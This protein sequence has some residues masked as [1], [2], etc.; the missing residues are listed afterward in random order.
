MLPL[1]GAIKVIEYMYSVKLV[2][3]TGFMGMYL[4][5]LTALPEGGGKVRIV[6][7]ADF[8][9]QWALKGLHNSLFKVLK[10]IPQDG[11]FDQWK[12]VQDHVLPRLCPDGPLPAKVSSRSLPAGVMSFQVNSFDLSAATDRLPLF[13]QVQILAIIADPIAALA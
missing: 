11:T 5:K 6:A 7:S 12:P 9:T 2:D 4:G 8:W 13:V 1:S 3:W 10:Q